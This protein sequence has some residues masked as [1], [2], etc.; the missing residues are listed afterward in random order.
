MAASL[1]EA[2]PVTVGAV[3]A[4]TGDTF[5]G[6]VLPVRVEAV[7]GLTVVM[8]CEAIPFEAFVTEALSPVPS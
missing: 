6:D 2:L 3:T 4:F 5:T 8:S 7:I 1:G